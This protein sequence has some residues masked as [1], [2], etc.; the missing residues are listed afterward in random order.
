MLRV[1]AVWMVF[2]GVCAFAQP[3]ADPLIALQHTVEKK[4]AE[5]D[6]LAKT[7]ESKLARMLPC[8][9]RVRSTIEEVNRAS[10]AR[11]A[12]LS[13]YLQGAAAQARAGAQKVEQAVA[14]QQITAREMETEGAEAEQERI[15]IDAQLADLAESLRRQAQLSDVHKALET[16]A[17][18]VRQRASTVQQET[19]RAALTAALTDLAAAQQAR[20]KA[21]QA[22]IAATAAEASR[23][24]DYYAARIARSQTECS[25]IN[26]GPAPQRKKK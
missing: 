4:T 10:D 15:A 22:E 23:W 3:P 1:C 24:N 19:Q 5:W 26:Q 7:L 13:Q 14:M 11:L 2:A 6:A 21:I 8:D 25:I 18:L 17:G 12:A 16:I 20:E 9:P